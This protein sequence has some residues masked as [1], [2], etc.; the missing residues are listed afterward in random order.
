MRFVSGPR[1][2]IMPGLKPDYNDWIPAGFT[3]RGSPDYGP[4]SGS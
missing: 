2:W 1:S 4:K 3:L